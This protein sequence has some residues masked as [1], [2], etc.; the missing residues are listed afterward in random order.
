MV[1]TVIAKR[2]LPG[3]GGGHFCMGSGGMLPGKCEN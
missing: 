3:G 1:L 2:T